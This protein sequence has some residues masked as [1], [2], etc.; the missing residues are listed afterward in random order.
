VIAPS[1]ICTTNSANTTQKYLAV[2]RIEGV[3]R[4]A[5]SGS[6]AG[7]WCGSSWAWRACHQPSKAMPA[8]RNSTL[9]ADHTHIEG[10]GVLSISGSLGQLLV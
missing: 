10:A 7:S 4:S 3:I 5:A 1:R 8:S 9:K 2:A 6:L